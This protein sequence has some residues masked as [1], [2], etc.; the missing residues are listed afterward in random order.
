MKVILLR[1][2]E[3]FLKGDNR[4]LFESMLIKN[5]K[6]KL[7][8]ETFKFEKTFGRYVISNYD[9]SREKVIIGKLKQVFGLY[10]LSCAL[11]LPS[12]VESI[13]SEIN[14][15][16]I[17]KKSFKV[18]VKRADKKFPVSSMDFAKHLGGV[19]LDNNPNAEVDLYNPQVE[20]H[21]DIRLNGK[22][23]L[24]YDTIKCQ[25][26]LPLGCAGKG[27]LLLSGG[28]DSPVAGYLVGKRGLEI[29]ALHF[30]SYPYTSEM[31]RDKVITLA[32][33]LVPFV[34]KIKLHMISFTKVQEMIH[35][36]CS[37]EYMITIMRRIMMR[38]AEQICNKYELGAIVTGESLGQV[39]SQTMQ[40]MTVTGGVVEIKP[41]FRP[42]ITMDK[43][44]IMKISKDI[45]TYETSILPY[46]DC[47]TVFLPK[48]PVIKPTIDRCE[49]EESK[50]DI[51]ALIKECMFS[52]EIIEIE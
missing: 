52:E 17:G 48:N 38:I 3:L 24:F 36:H 40:S 19:I 10:S 23:Y 1:F 4:Y 33:E 16:S 31:A 15:L 26:G 12:T 8:D 50:L 14:K 35:L 20:V 43:E 45:G 9:E 25:G 7:K 13:T 2:G 51:D 29:E 21:I 11:E 5:I 34:G 44:E 27:L 37:A 42:C 28:I 6:N 18:F 46:E 41:I 49:R 22:S 39:A 30:H 47:C 32:K